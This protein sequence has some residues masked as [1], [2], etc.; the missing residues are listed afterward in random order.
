MVFVEDDGDG[1]GD[2]RDGGSPGELAGTSVAG[3][4]ERPEE[5]AGE[6]GE[7]GR[8]ADSKHAREGCEFGPALAEED[9]DADGEDGDAEVEEDFDE[10]GTFGGGLCWAGRWGAASSLEGADAGGSG[11]VDEA[12]FDPA[13]QRFFRFGHCVRVGGGGRAVK[14]WARAGRVRE[15][16][17]ARRSPSPE[18][19]SGGHGAALDRGS[20][21]GTPAGPEGGSG[22]VRGAVPVA[23]GEELGADAEE[24]G[25]AET[26]RAGAAEGIDEADG[27]IDAGLVPGLPGGP[28][29]G[30]HGRL[31]RVHTGIID[32]YGRC[33]R[34]GAAIPESSLNRRAGLA[35]LHG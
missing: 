18:V 17:R 31:L 32:G 16:V 27:V 8:D 20:G 6:E 9:D 19:S 22:G 30:G 13:P 24:D 11:L 23:D 21:E 1:A 3:L 14:G 25:G 2:E 35:E 33:W 34:F 10:A 5:G 4:A 12:G 29:D 15:A 26:S 28:I 7:G